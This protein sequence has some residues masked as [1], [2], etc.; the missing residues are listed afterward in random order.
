MCCY[1][2]ESEQKNAS[3]CAIDIQQKSIPTSFSSKKHRAG[4]WRSKTVTINKFATIGWVSVGISV[5]NLIIIDY[6]GLVRGHL[7]NVAEWKMEEKSTKK[8]LFCTNSFLSVCRLNR[9]KKRRLKSIFYWHT[10]KYD[11]LPTRM[12]ARINTHSQQACQ[13]VRAGHEALHLTQPKM[14][15]PDLPSP[16]DLMMHR[17]SVDHQGAVHIVWEKV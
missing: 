3:N 11:C 17:H 7:L 16:G 14:P 4:R 8:N 6:L 9:N 10:Y 2:T 5:C 12:Q 15:E 13:L 1:K